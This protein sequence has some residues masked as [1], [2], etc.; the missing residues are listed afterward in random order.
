MPARPLVPALR[1]LG[2]SPLLRRPVAAAAPGRG[3]R[4][5]RQARSTRRRWAPHGGPSHDHRHHRRAVP[6]RAIRRDARILGAIADFG[7]TTQQSLG[8]HLQRHVTGD[9][10]NSTLEDQATNDWAVVCGDERIL[11]AYRLADQTRIWVITEA[12]RSATT[13]LLPEEY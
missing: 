2:A 11:S 7:E 3:R 13:V 1:S 9:W 10:V 6:A 4:A 8:D 12:D 5:L